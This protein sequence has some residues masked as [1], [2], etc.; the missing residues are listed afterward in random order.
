MYDAPVILLAVNK[1]NSECL[2]EDRRC[3]YKW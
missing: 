1:Y 3:I 2:Y